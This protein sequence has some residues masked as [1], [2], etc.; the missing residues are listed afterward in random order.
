MSVPCPAVKPDCIGWR[1]PRRCRTPIIL[2]IMIAVQIFFDVSNR[3]IGRSLL[4][5]MF[6]VS[7]FDTRTTHLSFHQL[8]VYLSVHMKFIASYICKVLYSVSPLFHHVYRA[9][10]YSR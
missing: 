10:H 7:Y 5:D 3:L 2:E 9:A 6:G 8:G 4:V 1:L